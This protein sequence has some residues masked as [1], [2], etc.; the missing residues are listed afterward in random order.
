[1]QFS[2]LLAADEEASFVSRS[3]RIH[4]HCERARLRALKARLFSLAVIAKGRVI[5]ARPRKYQLG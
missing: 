2:V 5:R 4:A 1:M 3:R